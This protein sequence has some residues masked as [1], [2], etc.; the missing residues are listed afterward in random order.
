MNM[1]AKWSSVTE[2][3]HMDRLCF[4][5]GWGLV[6]YGAWPWQCTWLDMLC[7]GFAATVCLELWNLIS[8]K[9][10]ECRDGGCDTGL[11]RTL[12]WVLWHW[13]TAGTDSFPC[14]RRS[15]A[16]IWSVPFGMHWE[17]NFFHFVSVSH[18]IIPSSSVT[19]PAEG[20]DNLCSLPGQ[21][22][23]HSSK[24]PFPPLSSLGFQPLTGWSIW[25]LIFPILYG[26]LYPAFC[27]WT[28]LPC[29]LWMR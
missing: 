10:F 15:N 13:P 19:A 11:V 28:I 9:R 5:L 25:L 26:I 21:L 14:I 18:I 8:W 27:N 23:L 29:S 1:L 7:G 4:G 3:Q 6:A 17:I 16:S 12:G 22:L 24:K 2:W 20:V